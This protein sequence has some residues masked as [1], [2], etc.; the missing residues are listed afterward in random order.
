MKQKTFTALE[1]YCMAFL[2]G[3]EKMYG[4][5]DAFSLIPPTQRE[6][7]LQ[8][9]TDLLLD[10][11]CLEM[12]FDG[13]LALSPDGAFVVEAV[14]SCESCLIVCRNSPKEGSLTSIFWRGGETF[15]RADLRKDLYCFSEC[16]AESVREALPVWRLKPAEEEAESVEAEISQSVLG[17]AKRYLAEGNRQEALRLLQQN[18]I[19]RRPAGLLA[20]A[21]EEKLR[22]LGLTVV[23]PRGEKPGKFNAA[24]LAGE[25]RLLSLKASERNGQPGTR[26]ESITEDRLGQ[27]TEAMLRH[28]LPEEQEKKS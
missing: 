8:R 4:I 19:G 15:L 12:D 10:K 24:W 16:T 18:G 1:I 23:S 14:T 2:A 28:F 25:D 26:F 3:K 21:L 20:D 17:K 22:Y 13:A 6:E 7:T 11:G 27:E 5:A 9:E